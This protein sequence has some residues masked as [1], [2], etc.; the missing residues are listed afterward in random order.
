VVLSLLGEEPSSVTCQGGEFLSETVADVTMSQLR[1]PSGVQAHIFVSWLHPFK[2]QRLVVVGSEKMAVIDDTAEDKLVLY[3]HRIEW[4]NRIPTAIK[5]AAEKVALAADEPLR[6]ECQHFLDCVATRVRPKTDGREGIRVLK[7][8]DA[9]Q[10]ALQETSTYDGDP[11]NGIQ[12]PASGKRAA[13]DNF[14]ADSTACIDAGSQIGQG[15]KIWNFTHVMKDARIGQGCSIGQ[16]C[17]ISPGVVIGDNVKIQ[18]NVSVYTG[19]EVED[20]VFLGPSC[21]LTNVTN[22]RSQVNRRAIYEK[23]IIRRG[24][25]VGANATI[26]CG[27]EIG[28]Y[29]FIAAGAVVTKDVP[30]Y[31]LVMGAPGRHAG[32]MSRHGHRLTEFDAEGIATCPESGYGYQLNADGTLHCLDLDESESLPDDRAVG[33][34]SYRSFKD[35]QPNRS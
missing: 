2:E 34:A 7:V 20:D 21:V 4:I 32:W 35:K 31:G 10:N 18:N 15:T 9:C 16:N 27:V 1:F 25:T 14:F 23:T 17:C 28:R 26:V 8:L 24:A 6:V 11:T 19:T 12:P 3:P 22:P 13:T 33:H 5:A 30:Q 29:A